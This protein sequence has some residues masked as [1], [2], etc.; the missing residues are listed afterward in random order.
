VKCLN[1]DKDLTP[2]RT[3]RPPKYC[4]KTCRQ[5][6]FRRRRGQVEGQGKRG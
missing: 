5:T 2:A 3:G 6:A 1:C 4:S